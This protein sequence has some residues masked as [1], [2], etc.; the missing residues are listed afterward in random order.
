M[1]WCEN[2]I[3]EKT[4]GESCKKSKKN[5]TTMWHVLT[6]DP[7]FYIEFLFALALLILFHSITDLVIVQ[8]D[9]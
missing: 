5:A 2:G 8:D 1:K 6:T 3:V 4:R 9:N 7:R